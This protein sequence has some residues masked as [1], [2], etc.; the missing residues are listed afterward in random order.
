MRRFKNQFMTNEVTSIQKHHVYKIK[1]IRSG[2]EIRCISGLLWIT[3][4][5]DGIDR[6]LKPGD[7]YQS[8]ISNDI[9]IEAF[10]DSRIEVS[11]LRNASF[12]GFDQQ[13]MNGHQLAGA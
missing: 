4:Q 7:I 2:K 11:S 13:Q 12:I 10:D 9:L 8:R 3:Q 6:I 1:N 5:G